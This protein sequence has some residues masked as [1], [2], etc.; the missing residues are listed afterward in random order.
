[1][2]EEK[3]RGS[4][5]EVCRFVC[6]CVCISDRGAGMC[7]TEHIQRT[8]W[9]HEMI[10]SWDIGV[11]TVMMVSMSYVLTV[12][13]FWCKVSCRVSRCS[14]YGK[15][16]TTITFLPPEGAMVKKTQHLERS[17]AWLLTELTSPDWGFCPVLLHINWSVPELFGIT[18]V[19]YS[20][21]VHNSSHF[22]PLQPGCS[23]APEPGRLREESHA[24]IFRNTMV[25]FPATWPLR[26][27]LS[28]LECY[29]CCRLP[30]GKEAGKIPFWKGTEERRRSLVRATSWTASDRLRVCPVLSR[31]QN[32]KE[33]PSVKCAQKCLCLHHKPINKTH[34]R[35][36]KKKKSGE[37]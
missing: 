18:C 35:Y 6:I 3:F 17:L 23:S 29:V 14:E 7:S 16:T 15:K 21:Y 37:T 22:D 20:V 19:L 12:K 27:A 4:V 1:M 31:T 2:T 33:L 36:L 11:C 25:P 8:G 32:M 26:R 13:A 10:P 24:N 28:Q 34:K 30:C 9:A 5:A